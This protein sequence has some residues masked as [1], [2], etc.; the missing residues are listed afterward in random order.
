[1]ENL[2]VK[3]TD[4]IQTTLTEIQSKLQSDDS[5]DAVLALNPDIAIAARD[6]VKGAGSRPRSR[7]STSRATS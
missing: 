3:G 2:Q 4:D 1:M 5:I 7:R 6:A